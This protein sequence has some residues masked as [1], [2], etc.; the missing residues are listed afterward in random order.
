MSAK[1]EIAI[2]RRFLLIGVVLIAACLLLV[3]IRRCNSKGKEGDTVA[4]SPTPAPTRMWWQAQTPSPSSPST[5]PSTGSGQGS[6]RS[7]VLT[8][9]A[10]V[11]AEALNIREG[12]GSDYKVLGQVHR[13]DVV[14]ILA[15]NSDGSWYKIQFEKLVGWVSAAYV[16]MIAQAV[17]PFDEALRQAQDGQGSPQAVAMAPASGGD[18]LCPCPCTPTPTTAVVIA[19]TPTKNPAPTPRPTGV[20]PTPVPTGDACPPNICT[21]PVRIVTSTPEA[22]PPEGCLQTPTPTPPPPPD[23]EVVIEVICEE[24][25]QPAYGINVALLVEPGIRQRALDRVAELGFNW[26]KVQIRWL[27][28]EAS[29]GQYTQSLEWLDQAVNDTHARGFNIL[30][31]VVGAPD[32]AR[33]PGADPSTTAPP[34][35]PQ[36]YADFLV[37]LADRYYGKVQAS[38]SGTS[39]TWPASGAA[40][41]E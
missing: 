22:C 19:P 14:E 4:L 10:R 6:G 34:A 35:N 12:P 7:Q 15:Q 9:K 38:R 28:F 2:S 17:R 13:G 26:V 23:G 30:L 5:S 33:A 39:R 20:S 41:A 25:P 31:T 29:K 16:E 3:G 36:D 18:C 24:V 32:W 21:P 8:L 40:G 37:F 1:K 11:T 27:D